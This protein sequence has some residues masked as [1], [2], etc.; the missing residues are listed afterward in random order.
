MQGKRTHLCDFPEALQEITKIVL[1]VKYILKGLF[2][3][4]CIKDLISR[5]QKS[6]KLPQETG[7]LNQ[8]RIMGAW[9]TTSGSVFNKSGSKHFKIKK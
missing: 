2:I 6:K 9:E 3:F 7:T 4:F 1:G 5:K 8:G